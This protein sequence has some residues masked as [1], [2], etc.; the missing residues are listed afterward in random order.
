MGRLLGG[1]KFPQKPVRKEE[2]GFSQGPHSLLYK[3]WNE[4]DISHDWKVG[5]L[6]SVKLPKKGSVRTGVTLFF[7]TIVSKVLCKII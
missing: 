5:L 7:L 4:E 2:Y 1:T 3:N 6:R